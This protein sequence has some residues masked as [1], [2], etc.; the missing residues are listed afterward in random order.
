MKKYS[1]I[2]FAIC[3]LSHSGL[4]MAEPQKTVEQTIPSRVLNE[5]KR[6]IVTVLIENDSI[7]AGTDRNYTSGVSINYTD[8]NAEFPKIAHRIDRFLHSI[9]IKHPA[10]IIH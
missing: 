1:V 2:Y 3:I 4:S 6:N 9:L 8:V 5:P 10:F 7:G